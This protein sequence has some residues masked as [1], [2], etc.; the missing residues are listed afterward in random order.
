MKIL[1]D[2]IC[3]KQHPPQAPK[4]ILFIPDGMKE[5]KLCGDVVGVGKKADVNVGDT[6][7]F[8]KFAFE[9]VNIDGTELLFL[10]EGELSLIY[11]NK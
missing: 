4:S 11:K 6:V 10:R 3:V 2:W 9:K 1:G 5:Q 8:S 7:V